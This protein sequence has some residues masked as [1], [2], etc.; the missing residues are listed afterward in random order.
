MDI[1]APGP[2]NMYEDIKEI[3][4]STPPYFTTKQFSNVIQEVNE[5]LQKLLETR[6]PVLV[7]CG[8]AS[9]GM[10]L[11]ISNFFSFHDRVLI[12]NTGKYSANWGEVCK[13]YSVSPMLMRGGVFY[14]PPCIE[15]F[16]EVLKLNGCS[17]A[18]V[19]LVH[20]ETTNGVLTPIHQY[21]DEIRKCCKNALVVIDATSSFL[22]EDIA[23]DQFDVII[24]ATQKG[25]SLPP[26]MFMMSV[27]K[28]AFKRAEESNLPSY[29]F[30]VLE[31]RR[32]LEKNITTF[33][34]NSNLYMAL[35]AMLRLILSRGGLSYTKRVAELRADIVRLH[36]KIFDLYNK[37]HPT[38]AVSAFKCRNSNRL[39]DFCKSRNILLGAGV[40]ELDNKI[41]RIRHFGLGHYEPQHLTDTINEWGESNDSETSSN[42]T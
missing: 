9:L 4:S 34:P 15:N 36:L 30:N 14:S 6:N 10:E 35:R 25:L 20:T 32:R 18:G 29:Y 12:I 22:S 23:G 13:R 27:S 41:F 17:L 38:N 11:A 42:G 5:N 33:T 21:V 2:F 37:D 16:N 3:Y 19:L 39:I 31:E 40:R 7:G 8:T 24:T 28:K 26:G 1:Y